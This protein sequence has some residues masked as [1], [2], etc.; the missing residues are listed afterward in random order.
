M[1]PGGT[2]TPAS[3]VTRIVVSFWWLTVIV[4]YAVYTGN[5]TAFLAVK[6][7]NMPIK[8]LEDLASSVDISIGVQNGIV[9]MTLLKVRS[10]KWILL[11]QSIPQGQG[12]ECAS[13]HVGKLSV[14]ICLLTVIGILQKHI[15]YKYKY[16][17]RLI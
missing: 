6:K 4:I 14:Y 5:L 2:S 3:S 9:Q 10:L 8:T 13:S 17:I 16:N 11:P 15:L 12:L 1:F 7:V